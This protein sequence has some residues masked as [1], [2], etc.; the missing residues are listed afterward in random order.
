MLTAVK[1]LY[2]WN[3]LKDLL[4]YIYLDYPHYSIHLSTSISI[5]VGITTL[6]NAS[7]APLVITISFLPSFKLMVARTS[8]MTRP[9][10]Q[11]ART[12][13]SGKMTAW[14]PQIK[15]RLRIQHLDHAAQKRPHRIVCSHPPREIPRRR[16]MS[17]RS[18]AECE[19]TRVD[20]M[21]RLRP[22]PHRQNEKMH[23]S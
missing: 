3:E 6:S 20:W 2:H 5:L 11:P 7:K 1:I 22:K 17:Q 4:T 21:S 10:V 19:A 12:H 18:V 23:N 15:L 8:Y 14:R 9:T 16:I 13:G